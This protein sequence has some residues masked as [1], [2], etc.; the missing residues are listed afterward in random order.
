MCDKILINKNLFNKN[1]VFYI[2]FLKEKGGGKVGKR[3]RKEEKD[4][5]RERGGREIEGGR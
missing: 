3:E 5:K 1:L 4:E 2:I